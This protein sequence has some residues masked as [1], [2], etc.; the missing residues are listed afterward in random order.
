[1]IDER[2]PGGVA[3]ERFRRRDRVDSGPRRAHLGF[4]RPLFH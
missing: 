2:L 1:M 4:G 3:I